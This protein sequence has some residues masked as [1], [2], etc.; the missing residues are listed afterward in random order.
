M[1]EGA[2]WEKRSEG[3]IM[4]PWMVQ[5]SSINIP[6]YGGGRRRAGGSLRVK[7]ALAALG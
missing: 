7:K 2:S 1:R 3:L 5:L 4:K 6:L